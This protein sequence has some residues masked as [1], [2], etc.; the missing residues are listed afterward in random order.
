MDFKFF[1]TVPYLAYGLSA[2][3]LL[4]L[5]PFGAEINGAKSWFRIGGSTL[6]PSEFAKIGTCLAVAK[7]LESQPSHFRY[8]LN[9]RSMILYAII[10]LIPG[11]IMI[12]PD[13]GS[14][15]VYSS[16]II[17]MCIDGLSF[18]IPILGIVAALLFILTN[19]YFEVEHLLIT[20][21]LLGSGISFFNKKFNFELPQLVTLLIIIL[22][23]TVPLAI[24]FF[25]EGS[26][27]IV[28]GIYAIIILIS[29]VNI[30][31]RRKYININMLVIGLALISLVVIG[32]STVFQKLP[33]HHQNRLNVLKGPLC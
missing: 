13:A 2:L 6:Q 3:L 22:S 25:V 33:I 29:L 17:M 31:F 27:L 15:L 32:S 16:F 8:G 19:L 23:F 26:N 28:I 11:L 24:L 14:A 20:I 10:F 21:I 18:A 9:S 1:L 5:I 30:L 4:L 12:Q 7:Y